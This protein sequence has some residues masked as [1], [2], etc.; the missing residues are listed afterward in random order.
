MQLNDIVRALRRRWYILLPALALA[1]SATA[2]AFV[3]LPRTYQAEGHVLLLSSSYTSKTT[4]GNP[5]L[6]FD[7]SLAVTADVIARSLMAQAEE[8]LEQ[9]GVTEA[10]LVKLADNSAGP[11]LAV[12][13]TGTSEAAVARTLDRLLELVS[14]RLGE[15][16]EESNAP[17]DTWIRSTLVTQPQEP[18]HNFRDTVR[19]VGMVGAVAVTGAVL[20]VFFMDGLLARRSDRRVSGEW[21]AYVK[22]VDGAPEA[23]AGS[24]QTSRINAPLI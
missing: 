21:H 22:S 6:Q 13:V 19:N 14:E 9:L 4:G 17:T 16:Q 8:E 3:A 24:G 18:Q 5:Y 20:F 7:S 11:I 12:E 1:V 15:I 23:L 2:A 10:F